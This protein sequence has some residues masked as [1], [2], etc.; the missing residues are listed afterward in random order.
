[1]KTSTLSQSAKEVLSHYWKM[2]WGEEVDIED[3][4]R[5]IEKNKAYALRHHPR[6]WLTYW[7]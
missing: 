1:M 4:E 3:I 2:V 6:K 7:D 5:R